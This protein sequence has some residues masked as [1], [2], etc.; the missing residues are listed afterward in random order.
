MEKVKAFAFAAAEFLDEEIEEL[1]SKFGKESP[2]F[3]DGEYRENK[4]SQHPHEWWAPQEACNEL[5]KLLE[6]SK[7]HD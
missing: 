5:N 6:S 7:E 4:E 3:K 2:F 1:E